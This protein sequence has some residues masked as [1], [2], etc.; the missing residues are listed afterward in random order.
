MP[1]T[2]GVIFNG[3]ESWA[4]RVYAW[5]GG[6]GYVQYDQPDE[7]FT[8]ETCLTENHDFCSMPNFS[9]CD[10]PIARYDH[11]KQGPLY[12]RCDEGNPGEVYTEIEFE[13]TDAVGWNGL[14]TCMDG[15]TIDN[16]C[17]LYWGNSGVSAQST[18]KEITIQNCEIGWGG[19]CI[20]MYIQQEPTREYMESGDGIYGVGVDGNVVGNYCHDIDGCGITF[21][22]PNEFKYSDGS[23]AD[24]SK[25]DAE[26]AGKLN[27]RCADNLI[28]RCGQGIWIHDDYQL[29]PIGTI[30]VDNNWIQ[31]IGE[32]YCHG[33]YCPMNGLAVDTLAQ[34]GDVNITNNTVFRCVDALYY[35]CG[36]EHLENN[37]FFR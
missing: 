22:A 14:F 16:L 9:G 10:Y 28:E 7:P 26:L 17:F 11:N 21:E 13:T 32:G 24:K 15:C 27:Y 30:I 34:R 4:D 37:A 36:K 29:V 12:L 18:M 20:H 31:S 35:G 23:N 19:N 6:K 25:Q 1:D 8:P 5:W 33:C 3:G 2:G